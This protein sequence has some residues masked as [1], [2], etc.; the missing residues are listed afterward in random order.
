MTNIGF[1]GFIGQ[2]PYVATVRKTGDLKVRCEVEGRGV[3]T[4]KEDS[5]KEGRFIG[6]QFSEVSVKSR[7]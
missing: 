4:G 2:F 3:K 6:G 1:A 7:I 5:R